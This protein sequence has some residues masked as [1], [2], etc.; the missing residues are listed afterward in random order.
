[1]RSGS[2]PS[3]SNSGKSYPRKE[4]GGYQDY[5]AQFYSADPKNNFLST[6]RLTNNYNTSRLNLKIYRFGIKSLIIW[7]GEAA[8]I[9]NAYRTIKYGKCQ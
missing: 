6:Q 7:Q 3:I 5:Q 2:N 8:I 1:M 4:M 9:I